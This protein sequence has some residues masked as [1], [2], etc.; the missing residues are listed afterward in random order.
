MMNHKWNAFVV[1]YTNIILGVTIYRASQNSAETFNMG[2]TRV[3]QVWSF[4]MRYLING[5]VNHE[6]VKSTMYLN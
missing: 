4:H 3:I 2:Q 1:F 5:S 6:I